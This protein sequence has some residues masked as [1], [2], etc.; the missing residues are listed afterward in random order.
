[1]RIPFFP[2]I[3]VL[4]ESIKL[5]SLAFVILF[6]KHYNNDKNDLSGSSS[7]QTADLKP[8]EKILVFLKNKKITTIVFGISSDKSVKI[9]KYFVKKNNLNKYVLF[10]EDLSPNYLFQDQIFIAHKSMGY[11]G[12]TSGPASLF[13]FLRKKIL[14]LNCPKSEEIPLCYDKN[15][16]KKFIKY[17]FKYTISKKKIILK[18]NNYKSYKSKIYE[19]SFQDIKK[20]IISFLLKNNYS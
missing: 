12:S 14:I 13:Y 9:L 5:R 11:I 18:T 17:L 1:M 7:R 4:I 6:I 16:E 10:L 15:N 8:I 20:Q 2:K 3:S 19:A